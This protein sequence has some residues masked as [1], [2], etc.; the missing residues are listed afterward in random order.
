MSRTTCIIVLMYIFF[1]CTSISGAQPDSMG[2][3]FWLA[4]MPNQFFSTL[5]FNITSAV[6]ATGTV[7]VPGLP[8]SASFTVAPNGMTQ[9]VVPGS[10]ALGNGTSV[11]MTENKGIHISSSNPVAVY[12]MN[13]Y[14]ESSDGFLGLPDNVLGIDYYILGYPDLVGCEAA[15]VALQNGT[16][17]TITLPAAFNGHAANVPY[18]VPLTQGETY[19][20]WTNWSATL[21]FSG[22]HFQSNNPIAVYG[23]SQ[24]ANVPAAYNTCDV[25][26]EELFPTSTWGNIYLTVP[27][28]TRLNGDTFRVLASQNGTSVGVNGTNVANLNQG[29]LWE[30]IISSGSQIVASKP[31]L[32]AQY[33]NSNSYDNVSYADPSEMQVQSESQYCSHYI[34]APDI[35]DFAPNFINVVAPVSAVGAVTINSIGIPA[36][37]F[38]PI[39]TS[40]YEGAQISVTCAACVVDAPLPIGVSVYGFAYE[41]SYSYPGGMIVPPLTPTPTQGL[42]S[43]QTAIPLALQL[44]PRR[45]NPNPAGNGGIWLPYSINTPAWVDFRVYDVSGE[46]VRTW[47]SDPQFEPAGTLERFWDLRNSAGANTASGVFFVLIHAR[48]LAGDQEQIQEIFAVA[49]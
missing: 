34:L 13:H 43:I 31:V 19:L 4:F 6:G 21:D 46:L 23:G 37:S 11:E 15:A 28:A 8:F 2:T 33:A 48:S 27:L 12:G 49:R 47:N 14:L 1:P 10:V 26:I 42:T 17:L 40:G 24:C 36:T 30:G 32:V 45:P 16:T 9:V 7:D 35:A 3:D 20:I 38:V 5:S 39:G 29:D 44:T 41:D 22:A 25:L 18:T